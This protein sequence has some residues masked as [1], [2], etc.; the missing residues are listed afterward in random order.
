MR[1]LLHTILCAERTEAPHTSEKFADELS[2]SRHFK[3]GALSDG[4]PCITSVYWRHGTTGSAERL[5][6]ASRATLPWHDALSNRMQQR[7]VDWVAYNG[8]PI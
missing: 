8:R 7:V 3:S 1:C 6:I 4:G 5:G 2:D